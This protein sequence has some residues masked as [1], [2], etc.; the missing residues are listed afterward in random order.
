MQS[1]QRNFWMFGSYP[2]NSKAHATT[3]P[4][5]HLSKELPEVV[6]ILVDFG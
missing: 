5:K 2:V 1:D 6:F 4:E 3:Q